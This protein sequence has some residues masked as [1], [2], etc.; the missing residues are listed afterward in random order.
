MFR[1]VGAHIVYLQE[2]YSFYNVGTLALVPSNV[3]GGAEEG[4]EG[5]ATVV[6][7]V[8]L[9]HGLDL[10]LAGESE[11]PEAWWRLIVIVH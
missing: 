2:M 5:D 7:P 4:A 6:F 1:D 11:N 9:S 10:S 3:G 8:L